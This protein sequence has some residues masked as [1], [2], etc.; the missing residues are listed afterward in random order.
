MVRRLGKGG[1][2]MDVELLTGRRW[3]T[4]LDALADRLRG[5]HT[6][7]FAW[8]RVVVSSPAT[9]RIV[10]QEIAARLGISA[11]IEYVTPARLMGQLAERAGVAR[12]RSRW[13]GT[14]L[15]M[16]TWEAID[17]LAD[18]FPVLARAAD[19]GR[20]G[21]RR[22]TAQRIAR[23]FRWYLDVSPD[24]LG[25][26]LAGEDAGPDGEELAQRWAWQPALLRSAVDCLEVD[27]LDTLGATVNAAADDDV[28]TF[29]LAV[30][31]LTAPQ[32][33]A[34]EAFGSLTVIAPLGS[35][36]AA[37]AEALGADP[38][39][40]GDD[41]TP[42]PTEVSLHDSHGPARQVEVLRDE[43]TRAFEADPTLQPRDVA[44]VCPRPERYA[45]LLDAAFSNRVE[46]GHPG[47]QLRV[48][49]AAAPANN[50]VLM[51]LSTLLRLGELRAS[52]TDVV[53]LLL[54]APIAHRWR[55]ND[56]QAILELVGG[57]GIR[58]G[59]DAQHR[60]A[61]SLDGL[62]QNTWLRGLDRLLVGLAVSSGHEGSLQIAGTDAVEAS[63][64]ETVGALCEI[65]SRLRRLI[66]ETAAP[67]T[68]TEWV[69]RTRAILVDLIGPPRD[70]EWQVLHA[71]SVLSR[72]EADHVSS[73]TRLTRG[74]FAHLLTAAESAPRA[75]V[76]AGNGSLLVAPL[77]E[78]RHVEF[79]LVALLGVTDDVVPGGSGLAPDAVDLGDIAP[80]QRRRRLDQLLGHA[81]SAE[82]L[83]IVRQSASQR[84]N[85][86]VAPPSAVSW[87]LEELGVAP[88]P[89]AHPPTAT[90]EANFASPASF[91][92]A[93][94]SGAVARRS[95]SRAATVRLR[96]R[97]QA[98]LRPAGAAPAQV[99]VPQLARFLADPAKAFLRSAAG[100]PLFKEPSLNDDMP[101]ELNGLAQW[102]VVTTL[103]DALKQGTPLETVIRTL[104]SNE[105]LPPEEIG[106][107]EFARAKARAELLWSKA[108]PAYRSEITD[109]PVDL[110]FDLAGLGTI[111]L[112][113]EIRCRGGQALTMTPSKTA[114]KLIGPWLESLALTA[115]GTPTP[116]SVYR[117]VQDPSNWSDV[118]VDH[119]LVGDPDPAAARARLETALRA[120]VLGQ[121]RLIPAPATA[122]IC[123]AEEIRRDR[124]KRGSWR[125]QPD[126]RHDKWSS[127]GEAWELFYDQEVADLFV[128]PPSAEDPA[129]GQDSAFGAWAV[130]LYTGLMGGN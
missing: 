101:L 11:G 55:L 33:A 27:P 26:W 67:A 79:R 40:L 15:E 29:V 69:R 21:G 127:M 88:E 17:E 56:R 4:L 38:A 120:Y 61:F 23:L 8:S 46:G 95:A 60:A 20:V 30:D 78:L 65:V 1:V 75:R 126:Y 12:D 124:H 116:G 47:R 73:E 114:D 32:R 36:G 5:T 108:G 68:I 39:D 109:V 90:S 9:G 13:L 57:S 42:N 83:L 122:A 7:P 10:G 118:I 91:D 129:N 104:R 35:P 25:G 24:L 82:R 43:L 93:A 59:M 105:E 31:D 44:I 102:S 121:Y 110:E 85:D 6:D 66:A 76:A 53:E 92:V 106:R 117:F 123:Y 16:A 125:G 71:H 100:L 72:F 98:R 52:A 62:A 28:P 112:V 107:S 2:E 34:L 14:P 97:E 74:E 115:A 86:R 84:T 89:V 58:W 54:S 87:L 41:G 50:P 111:R 63:D 77:G 22:A 103:L 119:R 128:D 49:Q 80:D 70:D 96:R 19:P 64:L 81:R 51:L 99:S 18:Q 113:D 3:S 94:H 45:H 48:Q 130:A 37:W